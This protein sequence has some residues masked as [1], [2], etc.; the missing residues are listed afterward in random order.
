LI[1][2]NGKSVINLTQGGNV[3]GSQFPLSTDGDSVYEKDLK[4]SLLNPGTFTGQQL[5]TLFNNLDNVITDSSATNPKW[6]EFFLE[7]PVNNGSINLN[8]AIG[9]FSNV[10]IILKNRQDE[11]IK[12]IDDSANDTKYSNHAYPFTTK[13]YCCVRVEFHT[14]DEVN[15]GG[16]FIQKNSS[17]TIDSIDGL[18][19]LTNSSQTPLLADEVFTGKAEDTKDYGVIQ[20][21]L[22][23]D[24]AGTFSI[25]GRATKTSPWREIDE[26]TVVAG[27]DK[28]WSFQGVRRFM[29]IVYTNGGTDQTYF[30]LQM[31]LKPVYIKPSS[32]PIGG[33]VKANDDAELVKAQITGERPDNDFGNV[34]VTNGNNLKVSLEEYDS[35]FDTEPLPTQLHAVYTGSD[36]VAPVRMDSST[37]SLQ[38]VTYEHHEIHSGSHYYMANH[39]DFGNGASSDFAII[40]PDTTKWIHMTF[41][42]EGSYAV[43][44]D[45]Y[46]DSDFDGD[47]VAVDS[48]NNNR[49][50][51]NT[52]GMTITSDPTVNSVGD[53]IFAQQKGAN[54][55]AGSLERAQ[56]IILKQNTKY[57]FR[58]TN[59]STSTNTISWLAEWYEHTNRN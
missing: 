21:A 23:T 12:E 2:I 57:I 52:T 24:E 41:A 42:I 44:L 35:S 56:E 16:I 18:I 48:F 43:H 31:I 7:R 30:D 27:N 59:E 54:K 45:I 53:M 38:T 33:V 51:G 1:T 36:T 32:H 17:V 25:Q 50:S 4:L 8:T 3:V 9:D 39:D 55:Q 19:S 34:A 5:Q 49:N 6:F 47:G 20:V 13:N 40:T 28:A 14:A 22:A 29:R 26:Y 15:L 46:E 37:N 11:T 58:I 10:K